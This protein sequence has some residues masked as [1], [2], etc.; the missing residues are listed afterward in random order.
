MHPK[1]WNR[2]ANIFKS[3]K[4]QIS[5]LFLTSV[6]PEDEVGRAGAVRG[7]ERRFRNSGVLSCLKGKVLMGLSDAM[8]GLEFQF[9]FSKMINHLFLP[10]IGSKAR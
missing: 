7:N 9:M 8:P 1:W 4:H 5:L 10:P 2:K 6:L 3:F